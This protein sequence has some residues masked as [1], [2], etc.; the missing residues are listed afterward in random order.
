VAGVEATGGPSSTVGQCFNIP[1]MIS[2]TS[3]ARLSDGVPTT[4]VHGCMNR[5]G[6]EILTDDSPLGVV[7]RIYLEPT[8]SI[9]SAF[10]EVVYDKLIKFTPAGSR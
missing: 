9:G 10:P 2:C 7:F 8:T 3:F 6:S 1:S 5:D 4:L